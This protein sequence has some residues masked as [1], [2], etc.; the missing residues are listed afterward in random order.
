MVMLV[1]V[2]QSTGNVH[3]SSSVKKRSERSL[4]KKEEEEEEETERERERERERTKETKR[5]TSVHCDNG[6]MDITGV[7]LYL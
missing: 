2:S 1:E 7:Q 5:G 6:E 4:I 3:F